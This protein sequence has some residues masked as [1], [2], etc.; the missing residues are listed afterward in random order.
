M[1]FSFGFYRYHE[2][3]NKCLCSIVFIIQS[4][5]TKRV[6]RGKII[7]HCALFTSLPR[8]QMIA[9]LCECVSTQCKCNVGTRGVIVSKLYEIC[10]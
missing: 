5:A 3:H 8:L 4:Y 6:A 9:S 10:F 7:D 2:Q 1:V